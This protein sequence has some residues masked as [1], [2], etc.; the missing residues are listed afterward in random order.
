MTQEALSRLLK[1]PQALFPD[2]S[3]APLLAPCPDAAGPGAPWWII[4]LQSALLR[5]QDG[6][7]CRISP[8]IPDLRREK[9][10][11]LV[12]IVV[13]IWCS[14]WSSSVSH[15]SV[16]APICWLP[17]ATE[18]IFFIFFALSSACRSHQLCLK[19][20][21]HLACYSATQHPTRAGAGVD[22]WLCWVPPDPAERPHLVTSER[23]S[24]GKGKKPLLTRVPLRGAA[25]GKVGLQHLPSKPPEPKQCSGFQTHRS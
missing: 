17:L 8:L 3:W 6:S 18:K 21:V 9:S 12:F 22:L 13:V 15:G 5:A 2:L 16:A 24:R 14:S 4:G 25:F 23:F 1:F 7:S 11:E 10:L 19:A 20:L